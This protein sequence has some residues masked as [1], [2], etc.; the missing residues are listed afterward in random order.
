[1]Y[2]SSDNDIW[3][4]QRLLHDNVDEPDDEDLSIYQHDQLS[5]PRPTSPVD[6]MSNSARFVSKV[7]IIGCT[8][9]AVSLQ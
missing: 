4:Q 7:T 8:V 5:S 6:A 9:S 2:F 3:F 1:M